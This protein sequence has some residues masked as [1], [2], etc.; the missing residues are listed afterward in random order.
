MN[1]VRPTTIA[2]DGPKF[3]VR[4][5]IDIQAVAGFCLSIVH[6]SGLGQAAVALTL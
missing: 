5:T 2:S 4:H 1:S 3:E 6:G